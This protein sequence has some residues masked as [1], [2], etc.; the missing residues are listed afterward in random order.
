MKVKVSI[1][2]DE[3]TL[4]KV[5]QKLPGSAYRNKSHLVEHAVKKLLENDNNR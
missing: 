2:I 1:S 5:E 4:R 3:E